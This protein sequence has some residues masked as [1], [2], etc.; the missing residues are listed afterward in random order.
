MTATANQTF[1]AAQYNAQ[2]RDNFL[3]TASAQAVNTTGYFVA[4]GANGIVQ[5][6]MDSANVGT[7]E[8]TGSTSYTDLAT[9]GPSRTMVTGTSAMVWISATMSC[10]VTSAAVKASFAI[11]GASVAS[12]SDTW[13]V[14][15]DGVSAN[16]PARRGIAH[17]VLGLTAGTN[18]FTMK[19]ATVAGNTAIFQFR[20]ITVMP[21]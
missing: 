12:A 18:T 16:C 4:T 10:T 20:N 17:R 3:E 2:I 6:R 8:S 5:R 11:S 1:T 15:I 7:S 21:T 13:G 19:Y 14:A 9:V